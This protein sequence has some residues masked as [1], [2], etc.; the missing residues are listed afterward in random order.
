MSIDVPTANSGEY[1]YYRGTGTTSDD[2]VYIP[3]SYN[4]EGWYVDSNDYIITYDGNIMGNNN[5]FVNPVD[6]INEFYE[7]LKEENISLAEECG[8]DLSGIIDKFEEMFS[9]NL[10]IGDE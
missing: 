4:V 10:G 2:C 5:Y 9:D 6:K 7:W 3:T 8:A 1:I